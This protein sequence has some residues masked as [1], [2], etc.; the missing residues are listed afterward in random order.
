MTLLKLLQLSASPSVIVK[1][2]MKRDVISSEFLEG[3]PKMKD[4]MCQSLR[5]CGA[6]YDAA[7]F[8]FPA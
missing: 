6:T 2:I 3:I 8:C 5:A 4:F 7:N 1:K